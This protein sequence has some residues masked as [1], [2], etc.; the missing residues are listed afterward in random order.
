[1]KHS[2]TSWLSLLRCLQCLLAQWPA[3]HAYFDQLAK[4]ERNN[5]QV[6]QVASHLSNLEMKLICG[7]VL[8]ALQLLN[9]FTTIFQTN[10]SCIGTMQEDM[11]S[12]LRGYLANFIRSDV[13]IAADD[14]TAIDYKDRGNQLPDNSLAVDTETLLF[15][16]EKEDEVKG[17][18][19]EKWFFK[20][21]R[22]FYETAVFKML[23]KFPLKDK[24]VS[25]LSFLDPRNR[26]TTSSQ[27]IVCLSKRFMTEDPNVIDNIVCEFLAFQVAPGY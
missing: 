26:A 23:T 10:A 18:T 11:L 24:T 1:M 3:L 7:F 21:V 2:T 4:V 22:C 17:T 13:I 9:K 25:D 6:Q 14:I 27:A 8:Y 5:D 19:M 20:N 16:S 12:L 15:L